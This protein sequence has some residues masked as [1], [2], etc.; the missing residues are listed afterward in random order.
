MRARTLSQ[1]TVQEVLGVLR[2]F[3]AANLRAAT[4]DSIIGATWR[5]DGVDGARITAAARE[6]TDFDSMVAQRPYVDHPPTARDSTTRNRLVCQLNRRAEVIVDSAGSCERQGGRE[7]LGNPSTG[8]GRNSP[9]DRPEA[10]E[11]RLKG[12]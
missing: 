10:A 4:T 11:R 1:T 12:G 5:A 3:C 7:S 8:C 9:T 2:M 6:W